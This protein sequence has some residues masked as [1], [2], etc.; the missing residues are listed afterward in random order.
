[1][2]AVAKTDVD[3]HFFGELEPGRK[4][5]ILD[6]AAVVFSERGYDA[7]SMRDIAGRVGVTE[8]A[9]YRHFP[10]KEEL[11]LSLIRLAARRARSEAFALIDRVRPEC[12]REQIVDAMADRRRAFRRYAPVLK[13]VMT[14]AAHNPRFLEEFRDGIAVPIRERLTV[15][16]S[17][18]DSVLA[19]PEADAT[20]TERVRALMALFIGFVISSAILEDHADEAVADAALRVMRWDVRD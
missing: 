14:A 16:A 6:A 5:E 8:P 9:I 10:G 12:V 7:G 19:V 1:M 17:E 15:K 13:T 3:E 20:R 18:V 4:G 2:T 11:F